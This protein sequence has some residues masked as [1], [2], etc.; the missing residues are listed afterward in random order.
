MPY[1]L[2]DNATLTGVQRLMGEIPVRTRD[3]VE[4]D[5]AALDNMIQAILFYDDIVVV[6][7][8][9][10]KYK[11]ARK[12]R[13]EFL[14]FL[15]PQHYDLPKIKEVA[16]TQADR[17]QPVI[18]G[19]EFK[20]DDIAALLRN[21]KMHMI[22]TWDM[23]AS[24]FY[25]TMKLLGKP[26]TEEFSKYS[27]LSASIFQE[28]QDQHHVGE[29]TESDAILYDSSGKRIGNQYTVTTK[30][31]KIAE[32]AGMTPALE[33]F[34]AALRWVA[35]RSIY[36]SIAAQRLQADLFLYP[37][38]Q[39]YH[40]HYMK[41]RGD[42]GADFVSSLL[43]AMSKKMQKSLNVIINTGR[44]S[45]VDM[46]IPIFSAWLVEKTGNVKQ[47][48]DAA[49]DIRDE[50]P[51]AETRRQ[52]YEIRN[53]YDEGRLE[54]AVG[55]KQKSLDQLDKTLA[56]VRRRFGIETNQGVAVTKLIEVLN[57]V[58]SLAGLPGL[59]KVGKSISLPTWLTNVI[60]RRGAGALYRDINSE[61]AYYPRLG[62]ARDKLEA[63]VNVDDS[64]A[65]Y[66]PKVEDPRYKNYASDWK[67]PM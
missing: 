14:R 7:D 22:C 6:D 20:D 3:S 60:P 30:S 9:K 65:S 54:A 53:M 29:R 4:A 37:I 51:I 17:V 48:L 12:D 46:S 52:L 40:I 55:K 15:N 21:L 39:A 58:L 8:Y 47:V 50:R 42:Y 5:I 26:D 61:L 66:N 16:K 18:R 19:G 63:A 62:D 35:Y 33:R 10:Q 32:T 27:R 36:Y 43:N 31:G 25:L 41:K 45:R 64:K 34:I 67:I 13:F 56:E 11:K 28:L 44:A 23:S 57:P 49:W 38:R 24:I 59:P 1:A 2:L